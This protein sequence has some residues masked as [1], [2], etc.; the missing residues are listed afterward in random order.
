M[1]MVLT[2]LRQVTARNFTRR[3]LASALL[4]AFFGLSRS[5]SAQGL[6]YTFVKLQVPGSVYTD[7]TGVNNS[8]RV[9]G[10][11]YGADGIRHGYVYDGTTYTT[12]DYPG[13]LHTFLF[14]IDAAG[15]TVGSYSVASG[16]GP[17]HSMIV[18][19]GNF[20]SFDFPSRESDAR[21]INAG[22][23]IIGIYNSG[24]GT[25]DTGYMKVGNIFT[26][27]SVPAAQHTYAFGINDAG[28]VS[29]SYVGADGLLHGFLKSGT[30]FGTVNFP[31][32]T[33]TFIGGINNADAMVGWSQRGVNAP[34]GFLVTGL[35][36]RAIDFDLQ[37]ASGGQPQALN[38]GGQVVGNYSS[39]ECPQGCAF[40]ATPRTDILPSCD[41]ALSMQYAAGTLKMKFAALRTSVPF[42]WT[43]LVYALNAQLT[44]WSGPL[45]AVSPAFTFDVPLAFPAVGPVVGLSTLSRAN[46]D[47]ICADYAGVNTGG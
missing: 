37:G 4:I 5:A 35:R 45:A 29:G 19:S 34:S 47:V 17:W 30:T 2:R 33:Q 43:V 16:N 18:D 1:E 7:A 8:G 25:A 21:A 39:T 12:V 9:V 22:G 42:T 10:T 6:P 13:A 15:R 31:S 32:T 20:T 36:L 38:D 24:P 41:Q 27:V 26:N 40:L 23:R 11:Y 14:G 46:G 3:S 28:K 44:L